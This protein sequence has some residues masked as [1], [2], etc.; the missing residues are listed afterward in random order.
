MSESDTLSQ[1]QAHK[2]KHENLKERLAKRR[3]ERQ[4]IKEQTL[5]IMLGKVELILFYLNFVT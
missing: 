1:L 3:K 2:R 5:E 4:G